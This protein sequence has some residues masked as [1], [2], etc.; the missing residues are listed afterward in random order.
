MIVTEDE[1]EE[2]VAKPQEHSIRRIEICRAGADLPY[3]RQVGPTCGIYALDAAFKIRGK[4][5]APRKNVFGPRQP[6]VQRPPSMR[7]VAK[8]LNLSRLGEL[9][10]CEDVCSLSV[11]SGGGLPTIKRFASA[12]ALWSI[13]VEATNANC[14]IVFPYAAADDNG[15]PA[16]QNQAKGFAHWCLVFGYVEYTYNEIKR[17]FVTTYG[18]YQRVSPYRLFKSN[19]NIEDWP[20]QEWIKLSFWAKEPVGQKPWE[21]W[22][23]DWQAKATLKDDLQSMAR[24]TGPG[25]GFG[26]GDRN[27]VLHTILDPPSKTTA[28]LNYSATVLQDCT[29]KSEVLDAK[30]YKAALGGGCLVIA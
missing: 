24:S 13:I 4:Y 8:Q 20:R 7:T 1:I 26:I 2:M 9:G 17:V 27:R 22:K 5:I 18:I 14:G 21:L 16:W 29:R 11:A 19:Q 6:G 10:S 3:N 15:E 25:W 12:D 30:P 28:D 23:A